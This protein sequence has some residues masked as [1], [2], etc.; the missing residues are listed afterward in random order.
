MTYKQKDLITKL[1]TKLAVVYGGMGLPVNG[2][3]CAEAGIFR[4]VF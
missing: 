4:E 1:T 3:V 2:R